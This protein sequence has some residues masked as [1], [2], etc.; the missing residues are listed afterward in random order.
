MGGSIESQP[1]FFDPLQSLNAVKVYYYISAH[2]NYFKLREWSI[3]NLTINERS[4]VRQAQFAFNP[5]Q[6]LTTFLV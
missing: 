6:N 2:D 1:T 4:Y 5:S 3:K